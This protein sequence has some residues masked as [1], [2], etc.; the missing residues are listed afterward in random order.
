MSHSNRL[1]SLV[2][3]APGA[4]KKRTTPPEEATQLCFKSRMLQF[5]EARLS[6]KRHTDLVSIPQGAIQSRTFVPPY[7]SRLSFNSA[8]CN[9]KLRICVYSRECRQF[10]FRKVQFKAARGSGWTWAAHVSIPQG[11]I[12]SLLAPLL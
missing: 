10:Q 5:K 2:S 4:K 7:P 9:S 8:R 1:L 3:S 12:Q 6:S 11:A